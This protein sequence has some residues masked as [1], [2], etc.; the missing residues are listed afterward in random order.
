MIRVNLGQS[1]VIANIL[2]RVRVRVI[3]GLNFGE[4]RFMFVFQD[5]GERRLKKNFSSLHIK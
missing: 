2:L 4:E 1:L 3:A 5:A